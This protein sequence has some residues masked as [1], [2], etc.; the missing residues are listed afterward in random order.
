MEIGKIVQREKLKELVEAIFQESPTV[1]QAYSLPDSE[2]RIFNSP[3]EVMEYIS[4]VEG[5]KEN[6]VSLSIYYPKSEGFV[7]TKKIELNPK[8]CSGAKVRYSIEGWGLIHFQLWLKQSALTCDIKANSEKRALKWESTSPEL[9]SPEAWDWKVVGS[10]CRRLN[11]VLSK[12][13]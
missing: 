4:E 8:K 11:R 7:R 10:H 12:C 3:S 13:A 9:K 6:L 2:I 5:S 1:Y